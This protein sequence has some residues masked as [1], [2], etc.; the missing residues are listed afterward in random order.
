MSV[1]PILCSYTKSQEFQLI[2]VK[3]K[4]EKLNTLGQDDKFSEL[5]AQYFPNHQVYN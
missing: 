2:E 3:S 4:I 1:N 5:M